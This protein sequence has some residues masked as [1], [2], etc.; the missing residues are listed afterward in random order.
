[1]SIKRI[2]VPRLLK[3]EMDLYVIGQN[4]NVHSSYQFIFN[5]IL[6]ELVL[7]PNNMDTLSQRI[8]IYLFCIFCTNMPFQT[9]SY[10][11]HLN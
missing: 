10:K 4:E 9:F 3:H 11:E 7:T 8:F 2:N 1:M 5:Q 6:F